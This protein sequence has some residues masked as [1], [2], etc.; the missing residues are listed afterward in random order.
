MRNIPERQGIR[1]SAMN[2]VKGLA[3]RR[4]LGSK[5]N[6]GPFF[7]SIGDFGRCRPYCPIPVCRGSFRAKTTS[8]QGYRRDPNFLG[9]DATL[10]RGKIPLPIAPI[11][12][13][14]FE[15]DH[16]GNKH[17]LLKQFQRML[18][19]LRSIS[20]IS[21]NSLFS[22]KTWRL[23]YQRATIAVGIANILGGNCGG[24]KIR[25]EGD[26]QAAPSRREDLG[27]A[28]DLSQGSSRERLQLVCSGTVTLLKSVIFGFVK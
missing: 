21:E 16:R 15:P 3:R 7:P 2:E 22:R 12:A 10:A 5:L 20:Q 27:P 13:S 24:F 6:W 18:R 4:L 26:P 25:H 28:H 23:L 11:L 9:P 8:A 17:L 19:R 14:R 1:G